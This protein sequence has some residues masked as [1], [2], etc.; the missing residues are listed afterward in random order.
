MADRGWR[1]VTCLLLRKEDSII[2]TLSSRADYLILK[3]KEH[4]FKEKHLFLKISYIIHRKTILYE[5]CQATYFVSIFLLFTYIFSASLG[6]FQN[7]L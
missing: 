7:Y 2:G 4:F 6:G 5:I 3:L 1:H